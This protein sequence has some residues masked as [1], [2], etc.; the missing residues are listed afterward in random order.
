[1]H[2]LRSVASMPGVVEDFGDMRTNWF[3][4]DIE[5]RQLVKLLDRRSDQNFWIQPESLNAE[6]T[7][8][9]REVFLRPEHLV[10]ADDLADVLVLRI[11]SEKSLVKI[12][13]ISINL[14][15]AW[16]KDKASVLHS[17]A[18]K[19]EQELKQIISCH[20]ASNV[21][22]QYISKL[23]LVLGRINWFS[24]VVL[25]RAVVKVVPEK[26]KFNQTFLVRQ[27]SE[28]KVSG[29]VPHVGINISLVALPCPGSI[30]KDNEV[31][32]GEADNGESVEHHG[33]DSWGILN[34]NCSNRHLARN[35]K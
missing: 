10:N 15:E 17:T 12:N 29:F 25:D 21:K 27:V 14:S 18:C 9:S 30:V 28:I 20:R 2:T 1:M 7:E 8:P 4:T 13:F 34:Q 3:K 11:R 33:F 22:K 31:A 6:S 5:P 35:H 32:T 26:I 16:K 19:G 23:H 24:D